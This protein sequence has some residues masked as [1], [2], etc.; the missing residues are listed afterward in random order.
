MLGEM[1]GILLLTAEDSVP[2]PLWVNGERE[3][4]EFP[5]ERFACV[6]A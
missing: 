6:R 4:L 5:E 3:L 1:E 2:P